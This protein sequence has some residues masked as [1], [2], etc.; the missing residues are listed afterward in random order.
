MTIRT[1]FKTVDSQAGW[2]CLRKLNL[3][4]G[5]TTNTCR[6]LWRN[7][8]EGVPIV[9]DGNHVCRRQQLRIPGSGG[10]MWFPLHSPITSCN[11]RPPSLVERRLIDANARNRWN[12]KTPEVIVALLK[13]HEASLADQTGMGKTTL[14]LFLSRGS[15]LWIANS[16]NETTLSLFLT[17][18]ATSYLQIDYY[19]GFSNRDDRKD[20][21]RPVPARRR[22]RERRK[23][24][25]SRRGNCTSSRWRVLCDRFVEKPAVRLLEWDAL[26]NLNDWSIRWRSWRFHQAFQ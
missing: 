10:K 8:R 3:R 17:N 16:S 5:I 15:D 11:D 4:Q 2:K 7:G 23:P 22:G 20:A 21:W 13:P 18:W 1:G 14:I 19:S 12:R 6:G 24:Y 9:E 26:F 25:C